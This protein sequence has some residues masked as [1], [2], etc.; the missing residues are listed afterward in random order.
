[1]QWERNV[2]TG[3]DPER[4][5]YHAVD[6]GAVD[7]NAQLIALGKAL[8]P[9]MVFL[10]YGHVDKK[11]AMAVSAIHDV[12]SSQDYGLLVKSDDDITTGGVWRD[13]IKSM[14][15]QAIDR[16]VFVPL[17]SGASQA[18]RGSGSDLDLAFDVWTRPDRPG[19][20]PILPVELEKGGMATASR[21]ASRQAFRFWE[22]PDPSTAARELATVVRHHF[23]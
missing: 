12:L 19:H 9:A 6:L 18:S 3:L 13:E 7:F 14:I 20:I 10:S 16:G 4:Y 11:P 23:L 5:S 17:V 15:D 21:L 2:I 8:R 1:M 22:Y